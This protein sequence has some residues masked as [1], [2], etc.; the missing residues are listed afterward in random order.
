[1][2]EPDLRAGYSA[3][4][5][6]EAEAPLLEAG[7]PLMQRAA[8]GLADQLERMLPE[9]RTA[10]VFLLVGPGNN[11]GDALFAGARLAGRG[12]G[13]TLFPTS[14]RVHEAGL[15]A[16]LAAG[17]ELVPESE[18]TPPV[19]GARAATSDIVVDGVLG[20]GT[21]ASPALRGAARD[22]VAAVREALDAARPRPRVV[23][24]DLPS[25]V[26]PD[27]GSVADE[28]V[29]AADLTVTFGACKAG[30]LRPPGAGLAGRVVVVDIGLGPGLAGVEPLLPAPR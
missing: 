17:A 25:G 20:T 19:A 28:V 29:L 9:G 14:A 26:H 16:A 11:G 4:Q 13:V 3:R 22:V 23:A 15:V 12:H 18:R 1:V 24:V 10:R 30:L 6:R 21:S 8:D 2:A 5:V 7:V 27:E